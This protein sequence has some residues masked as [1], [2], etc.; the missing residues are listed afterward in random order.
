MTRT[1]AALTLLILAGLAGTASAQDTFPA[2]RIAR[3]RAFFER[4]AAASGSEHMDCITTL[5][6]AARILFED[7]MIPVGSQIDHTMA[8]LRGVGLAG[9]A[10]VIEFN[11]ERGRL[12]RGVTAP[13]SLRESVWDTV[14]GMTNGARGWNVFGLSL[15]DG[16]HSITLNVD[17][18][19][20]ASPT[21]YW[22]DQ[23]SS[24]AGFKAHTKETLDA[25]ITRLTSSWWNPVKKFK[26]RT[27][28]WRLTPVNSSR[29][30]TIAASNLSVRSGPGSNFEVLERA[31]RNQK[32]RILSQKGLWYEVERAD[33]SS[34]W[35]HSAYVRHGRAVA[36]PRAATSVTPG[37][38]G[39][40]AR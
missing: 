25:E 9:P 15:M 30:A 33:G 28:L 19:N 7:P 24:N 20:P 22:S 16:Y 13:H 1:T 39:L 35:V 21:I 31:S 34:G 18:T 5:N 26:T 10:R 29:V 27:T 37:L 23:W 6:A 4:N 14:I 32:F 2:E 38:T 3:T 40:I 36:P 12:T 11:D 17:T 8:A